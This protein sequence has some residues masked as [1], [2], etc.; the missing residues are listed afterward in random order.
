MPLPLVKP[1]LEFV[2][3]TLRFRDRERKTLAKR[4]REIQDVLV[5]VQSQL[6]EG[7]V[8]RTSAH[9]LA[10]IINFSNETLHGIFKIPNFDD[11]DKLFSKQLPH[12]GYLLRTADVF[13]DGQPRDH[14]EK[15][16]TAFEARPEDYK[17]SPASVGAA[18]VEIDRA[19]GVIRGAVKF[20]DE[21]KAEKIDEH[22]GAANKAKERP[23]RKTPSDKKNA[24][25]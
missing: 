16:M 22:V 19:I 10:T 9:E 6:A 2:R 13:V 8:P 21:G 5:A 14:V 17:V 20:L 1:F 11:I 15:Y 3:Q 12:I 18:I 24:S 4:L 7:V 25:K 23:K